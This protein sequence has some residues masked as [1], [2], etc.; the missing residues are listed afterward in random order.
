M[1]D[2]WERQGYKREKERDFTK[3][4]F[5]MLNKSSFQNLNNKI[6][7]SKEYEEYVSKFQI[8]V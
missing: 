6:S 1:R 3:W 8:F 5:R 2:K 7:F 4:Y